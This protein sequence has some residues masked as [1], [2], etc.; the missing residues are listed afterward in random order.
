VTLLRRG[1]THLWRGALVVAI[2][3]GGLW[4]A[5][6]GVAGVRWADV[7]QVLRGVV[8]WRL[9]VLAVVWLGGLGVY[10]VV[11]AAA[12]PGLGVRRGLLLN[13]T[14]SAVANVVPLGGAVATGLNWRMTRLWGHSNDDF[15]AY[16]VL[17]NALDV[18]TKLVF[19]LVGVGVLVAVSTPVPAPLWVV[20]GLCVAAL[21]LL[22]V[23][24]VLV[25]LR[26]TAARIR[27]LV[28]RGWSRLLPAS[29]GYVGAQLL[30]FVL[31]LGAVG[32]H[33]AFSVVLMAAAI[34][35]LG[36]LVPLTPGG[37]GVAEIGT[38]AW[39]VAMGVDPVGAVAGVLLYRIFLIALE[40]PLGG[41]LLGGWM[42]LRRWGTSHALGTAP[43]GEPA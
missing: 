15:V 20:A 38:V 11:L 36:T 8:W 40:I 17:T 41:A 3:A 4:V 6:H 18:T 34:E 22:S 31:S 5:T 13:L 24:S 28:V 35:R 2:C 27:A 43:E 25:R 37:T 9:G 23:G 19:P 30:L 12:M 39:L 16:C 10:S 33:P 14:G 29:V 21:I 42:F 7:V 1:W 32:L 26:Q